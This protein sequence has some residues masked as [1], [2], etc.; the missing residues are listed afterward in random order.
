MD[1]G[2]ITV[3]LTVTVS[4]KVHC[5]AGCSLILWSCS[6][7]CNLLTCRATFWHRGTSR[8]TNSADSQQVRCLVIMWLMLCVTLGLSVLAVSALMFVTYCYLQQQTVQIHSHKLIHNW[9]ICKF[10]WGS[11]VCHPLIYIYRCKMPKTSESLCCRRTSTPLWAKRQVRPY[12]LKGG[13]IWTGKVLLGQCFFEF[14]ALEYHNAGKK[15]EFGG[16]LPCDAIEAVPSWVG[17]LE[18]AAMILQQ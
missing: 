2:L 17:A 5:H 15:A 16:F 18:R 14:A 11:L 1:Y 4:H 9:N 3:T 12:R 6:C 13:K 7:S 8:A 10:D